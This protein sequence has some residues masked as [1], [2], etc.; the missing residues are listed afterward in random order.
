MVRISQKMLLLAANL[1]VPFGALIFMTGYFR[2]RPTT[3]TPAE[4]PTDRTDS[5]PFDKVV[6]MVIDALR[7]FVSLHKLTIATK[8]SDFMKLMTYS[9]FVY[10]EN[11]GFT[12]TQG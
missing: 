4:V 11:G 8:L 2:G 7:R 10:S 3:P 12:F 5:A 6:F 1:L 9:D